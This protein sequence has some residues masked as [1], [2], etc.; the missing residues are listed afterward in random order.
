MGHEFFR[1]LCNTQRTVRVLE[2]IEQSRKR[3]RTSLI[4]LQGGGTHLCVS[5]ITV[6]GVHVPYQLQTQSLDYAHGPDFQSF[7]YLYTTFLNMEIHLNMWNKTT[8]ESGRTMHAITSIVAPKKRATYAFWS[9]SSMKVVTSK[10]RT[11]K[12]ATLIV[13]QLSYQAVPRQKHEVKCP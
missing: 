7:N 3:V 10:S 11:S 6:V 9:S 5:H 2:Q 13:S 4:S 12:N 8:K 1:Q